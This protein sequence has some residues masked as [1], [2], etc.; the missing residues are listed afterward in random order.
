M[1]ELRELKLLDSTLIVWMGEFGRTPRI[2]ANNGRDHWS[3]SFTV[4][5]A[6]GGIK[7]G[8]AIGSTNADGIGVAQRPV[9]VPELHATIY[10]AVGVDPT[11]QN[12]SNTGKPIR[13]VDGGAKPIGE[14]FPAKADA[15]LRGVTAH[16]DRLARLPANLIK[17]KKTDAE[18]VEALY[19]AAVQRLP[20]EAEKAHALKYLQNAGN[21]E[22]ACRNLVW[23]L[24][25]S[26]EF[27][28]LHSL[29][30]TPPLANE[31]SET[32]HRVWK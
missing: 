17:A 30:L 15:K 16:L 32:L 24:V 5:L 22:E 10:T 9:T 14:V 29:K 2:N 18:I 23:A 19:T 27:F 8:Q 4:A 21:R 28:D 12:K 1:V 7:G 25:N 31:F 3:N 11:K 6:G 20:A 13:I 26:T